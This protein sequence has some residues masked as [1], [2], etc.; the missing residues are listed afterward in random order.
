MHLDQHRD[1]PELGE[2]R[3]TTDA[4]SQNDL[5]SSLFVTTTDASTFSESN[6]LGRID[7]RDTFN[8]IPQAYTALQ[9]I[10]HTER[11]QENHHQRAKTINVYT[12]QHH[13]S[14]QAMDVTF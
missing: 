3:G 9:E 13:G 6:T 8:E 14:D 10:Y 7:S 2:Q 11:R 4:F 12:D 5:V 1:N